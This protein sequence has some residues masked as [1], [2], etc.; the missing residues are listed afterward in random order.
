VNERGRDLLSNDTWEPLIEHNM[1]DSR[2]SVRLLLAIAIL[3]TSLF[4]TRYYDGHDFIHNVWAPTRGLLAGYNPYDV[5]EVEYFRAYRVPVVAGLYVP[6]TLMLH[7]PLAL[8]SRSRAADVMAVLNVALL[9]LGVLILIRPRSN[10]GYLT[11]AAAGSLIVASSAAQDT[12]YLGQLS[13][14]AF[15][16]LA[17]FVTGM[18]RKPRSDWLP[19]AGVILVSLK[20]Q[21]GLPLFAALGLLGHW[22]VLARAIIILA[23]ASMPAVALLFR[24]AGAPSTILGT[25]RDNLALVSQL[26]PCDLA[27]P[28]N[29]RIDLLGIISHLNGPALTGPVWTVLSFTALTVLLV[30]ALWLMRAYG[31]KELANPVVVTV[32]ALYVT[33]ALYHLTYDQLLLFVGPLAAVAAL[34]AG[35]VDRGTRL[36]AVGGVVLG[37]VGVLSRSGVRALMMDLGVPSLAVHRGWVMMPTLISLAVVAAWVFHMHLTGANRVAAA[38]EWRTS[39]PSSQRLG[40]H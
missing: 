25:I 1:L 20:P 34:S 4:A 30:T 15:V 16:G 6:A 36:V 21:S 2:H 27:N 18:Q 9:W 8:L 3:A 31:P 7:A 33:A 38:E 24:A 28:S 17:L 35:A 32:I 14:Y 40:P 10:R 13:G 12:I 11:A 39:G 26:P 19:V 22:K 23:A 5:S 37:C 29:L